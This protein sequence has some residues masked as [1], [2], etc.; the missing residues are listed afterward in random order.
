[1]KKMDEATGLTIEV[2]EGTAQGKY[3][4]YGFWSNYSSQIAKEI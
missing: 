3:P 2:P 1:M 4:Y